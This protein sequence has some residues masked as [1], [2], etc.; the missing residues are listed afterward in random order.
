ME[1]ILDLTQVE[2]PVGIV[3][4]YSPLNATSLQDVRLDLKS[5][6]IQAII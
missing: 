4:A 3:S 2:L 5:S 6:E 1:G